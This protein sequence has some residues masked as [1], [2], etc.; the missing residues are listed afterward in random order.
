VRQG[1][2]ATFGFSEWSPPQIEGAL[3]VAGAER[4]ISSQPQ[5]SLLWR[6]PRR[7]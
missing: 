1:K 4:F 2:R 6:R 3:A 7:R 5:Y